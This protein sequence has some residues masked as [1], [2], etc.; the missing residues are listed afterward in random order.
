MTMR[1]LKSVDGIPAR[2]GESVQ[3][4]ID[5]RDWGDNGPFYGRIDYLRAKLDDPEFCAG[6]KQGTR[7]EE[8]YAVGAAERFKF[9]MAAQEVLGLVFT[10]IR[11]GDTEKARKYIAVF[12]EKLKIPYTLDETGNVVV[13][14]I[15][16]GA[17][18]LSWNIGPNLPT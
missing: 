1:K 2:K 6:W 16:G 8:E 5:R 3:D 9:L 10:C 15:P 7:S 14:P 13:L 18:E 11:K 4:V 17:S 12:N